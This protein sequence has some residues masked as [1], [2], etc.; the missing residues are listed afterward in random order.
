MI[1]SSYT[2]FLDLRNYKSCLLLKI[3]EDHDEIERKRQER[4][5]MREWEQEGG[6]AREKEHERERR[7]ETYTCTE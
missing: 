7:Q 4:R 2:R 3:I 1:Q 6:D 5:P